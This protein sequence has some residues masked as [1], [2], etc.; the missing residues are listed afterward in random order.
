MHIT[1]FILLSA[2]ALLL[3][4]CA[5]Q[6]PVYQPTL[7][8]STLEDYQPSKANPQQLIHVEP[9]VSLEKYHKVMIDPLL[10]AQREK[11]GK[12]H[13]FS[14][15]AQN[16]I[17][18]YFQQ[19]LRRELAKQNVVVSDK[20]DADVV[21]LQ[22]TITGLDLEK[23]GMK[24]IDLLPAKLAIDLTKQAV[25]MEPYLLNIT[26]MTQLVDSKSNKLLVR[27]VNMRPGDSKV[28]KNEEPTLADVKSAIDDWSKITA[29]QLGSHLGKKNNK[30]K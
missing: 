26:S 15:G 6:Q 27:A 4:G 13:F 19:Q 8:A 10:F 24:V 22:A 20:A 14:A 3:H 23:P 30:I 21:R 12:V 2:T 25:G 9:G 5:T 16:E 11:D 28:T 1:R 18:N 17:G 7:T 29:S